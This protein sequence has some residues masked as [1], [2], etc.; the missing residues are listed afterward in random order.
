M[1]TFD[2]S[3]AECLVF[4]FKKGLLSRVAHDLKLR[5]DR[6]TVEV[7]DDRSAIAVQLDLR[8]LRVV[9]AMHRGREAPSK[10]DRA[11]HEKI[12]ETLRDEVLDTARHPSTTYAST[13]IEPEGDGYRVAGELTL[14][15][16][17]R[18]VPLHVRREGTR[19]TAE[20]TLHQ[21]DFGIRP[22]KAALGALQIEPDVRVRVSAPVP[23]D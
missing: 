3:T 7:A 22:Y 11:D 16:V 6:F 13:K 9:C 19:L 21:P 23:E 20:V 17:S 14:R 4:T 5:V 10:L 2:A 1:S 12:E 18:P 8:S 15:G